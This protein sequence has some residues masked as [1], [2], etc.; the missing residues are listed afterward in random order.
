MIAEIGTP[1]WCSVRN[2]AEGHWAN[3]AVKRLLGWAPRTGL[4]SASF[5]PG[6]QGRPCQSRPSAGGSPSPP[7]H[8]TLP[9]LVSTTLVKIV[10]RA[11]VFIMFGLLLLLVPGATPKKPALR[12]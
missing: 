10:L 12:D 6:F 2:E 7:S 1:W 3:G 8:H 5:R 9:S 4:P 11:M